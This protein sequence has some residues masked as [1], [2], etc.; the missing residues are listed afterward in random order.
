ME[1]KSSNAPVVVIAFTVVIIVAMICGMVIWLMQRS[2]AMNERINDRLLEVRLQEA[3]A[4]SA[5]AQA[6]TPETVQPV[7]ASTPS[8]TEKALA[9]IQARLKR[10]EEAAK[11]EAAARRKA[12]QEMAAL[13]SKQHAPAPKAAPAPVVVTPQPQP[14]TPKVAP[15]SETPAQPTQKQ[16][17]LPKAKPR[18]APQETPAA[19]QR[20][21]SDGYPSNRI[22][23]PMGNDELDWQ[24]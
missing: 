6:A 19:Q 1:T 20:V 9:E 16:T 14:E 8:A 23:L 11:R 24:L 4:L 22:T 5:Q 12:E 17:T 7:D 18:P 3:K 21:G 10:A 15:K 13:R 2:M